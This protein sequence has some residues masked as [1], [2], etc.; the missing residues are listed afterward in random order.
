MRAIRVPSG[1][2]DGEAWFSYDVMRAA[3]LPSSFIVKIAR[4]GGGGGGGGDPR[5]KCDFGDASERSLQNTILPFVACAAAL[6]A[7]PVALSAATS[8]ATAIARTIHTAFLRTQ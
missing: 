3:P 4:G 1:D 6:D 7:M 2:Q 8:E 5:G